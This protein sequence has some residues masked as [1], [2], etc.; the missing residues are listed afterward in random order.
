MA[1][2]PL[3]PRVKVRVGVKVRVEA[4]SLDDYS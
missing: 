4:N 2:A 3:G 1:M